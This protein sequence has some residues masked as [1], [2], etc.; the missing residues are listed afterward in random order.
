MAVSQK[1]KKITSVQSTPTK[2]KNNNIS[3]TVKNNIGFLVFDMIDSK[4]N[5]LSRVVLLELKKHL[6]KITK[7]IQTRKTPLQAIVFQSNKEKI[8]IAGADINEI[9][10]IKSREEALEKVQLG[11][12]ILQK[13]ADLPILTIAVIEGVCIGGGLELAL[14][15][16]LR[17]AASEDYVRLGLPEV[18][19]GIIPGFGGT[20]RLSQIVGLIKALELITSG[21]IITSQVADK[22]HLVDRVVP[23]S[24]LS[25][26][27]LDYLQQLIIDS[28]RIL[29]I[30]KKEIKK[31][32]NY[33]FINNFT[34]TRAQHLILEKTKGDYPAPLKAL[35]VLRRTFG[36]PIEKGLKIEAEAFADIASTQLSK[37]LIKLFFINEKIRKENWGKK[38][39]INKKNQ[40]SSAGI[41]G[42]GVMGGGIAW[43]FS[44][45]DLNVKLADLNWAALRSGFLQI[46][47]NFDLQVKKKKLTPAQA[48]I[49]LNKISFGL[50]QGGFLY[51]DLVIEAV[52]EDINIKKK[53]FKALE[54]KVRPETLIASN[55]SA[56]SVS[57]MAKNLKYPERFLGIHFFNPV[58]R[59]PLV[60]IIP[61]SQTSPLA[62]AK[63]VNLVKRM[64]KVP[65]VVKDCPGFLVNRILLPYINEAGY[66]L[67]DG[68]NIF[69][70]DKAL[71]GFGLPM[72]PLRLL[73]T[74]GIDIGSKVAQTLEKAYG[75]RAKSNQI[76]SH[77]L[78]Q[79]FLG[80]KNK[81]GLYSYQDK[82]GPKA[83]KKVYQ[84]LKE[85]SNYKYHKYQIDGEIIL[86]RC[87]YMMLNEATFCLQEEIV[88]SPEYLD[89][90]LIVGIGFPAF[91]GGILRY[92]DQMG[93]NTIVE[94]MEYLAD[95]WGQRFAPS[96][97]LRKMAKNNKMFY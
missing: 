90:A 72:G 87:F 73:D 60:E 8:F 83:N 35:K 23:Q 68:C 86:Q 54:K 42:A 17:I 40:I 14:S 50:D 69:D 91:R 74:V 78:A 2:A 79:G 57:E 21:K 52:V 62:I 67:E 94:Q 65:I 19:L 70:I 93:V 71:L 49:K 84:L 10:A 15:C 44:A 61:H 58:N 34:F 30:R 38:I 36:I 26:Y 82:K 47:S 46:K 76:F 6:D 29:K 85:N 16:D 28:K 31:R 1:T 13:I 22:L 88:E 56:L 37:N 97:L 95:R 20:Q 33:F 63:V 89:M 51:K 48:K 7:N 77:L 59:M 11:Q 25:L 53:V 3:F 45:I 66:L 64:N 27:F 4:I 18:N 81:K 9:K 80:V 75:L 5:I 24:Y 96:P 55:T 92:A 43:A 41:L 12:S 39:I 32:Q